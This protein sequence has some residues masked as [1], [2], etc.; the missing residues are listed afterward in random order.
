MRTAT[1]SPDAAPDRVA[2][3]RILSRVRAKIAA[4]RIASDPLATLRARESCLKAD[5]LDVRKQ[6][7]A[8]T[9]SDKVGAYFAHDPATLYREWVR[10]D[11]MGVG[12]PSAKAARDA[13]ARAEYGSTNAK[14]IRAVWMNRARVGV[15]TAAE[16]AFLST[17]SP[18]TARLEYS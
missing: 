17:L 13:Y 12:L 4:G 10:L 1:T 15:P 3:L 16:S 11:P 8:L 18:S 7:A 2:S 14:A 6:I 9:A 5:L